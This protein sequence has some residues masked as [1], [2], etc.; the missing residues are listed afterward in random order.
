MAGPPGS[1]VG[2]G[3]DL[4]R[5]D[6]AI[7]SG[8]H[9]IS[10][11]D[12]GGFE[13]SASGAGARWSVVRSDWNCPSAAASSAVWSR[14]PEVSEEAAVGSQRRGRDRNLT[15]DGMVL[16]RFGVRSAFIH[17]W[18][19]KPEPASG[20]SAMFRHQGEMVLTTIPPPSA[21]RSS[22]YTR[23]AK[24]EGLGFTWFAC[25]AFRLPNVWES[26]DYPEIL[27]PYSS[28]SH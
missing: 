1:S 18:E 13:P 26:A 12:A 28:R 20:N 27:S 11:R 22:L 16:D 9:R 3:V 21:S 10:C 2:T 8:R 17:S 6:S 5:G 15:S 23:T 4:G 24:G 14:R 19:S 7:A 25:R